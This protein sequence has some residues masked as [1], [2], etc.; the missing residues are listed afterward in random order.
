MK[1]RRSTRR[2]RGFI[3]NPYVFGAGGG[4]PTYTFSNV[5]LLLHGSARPFIDSS[6]NKRP[7]CNQIA[8]C[9]L[10]SGKIAF[11]TT[12]SGLFVRGADTD[13]QF[14]TGAFFVSARVA[15]GAYGTTARIFDTRPVS[16]SSNG[17]AV[18][19]QAVTRAPFITIE[20]TNYGVGGGGLPSSNL[21]A[22]SGAESTISFSYDGTD[23]RCF[24]DGAL[25]WTHTVS[26]NIDTGGFICVGNSVSSNVPDSAGANTSET[27]RDLIVIKG[28]AVV[29]AAFTVP[30]TWTD[31]G[32]VIE[33]YNPVTYANVKLNCHMSGANGGTTFTDTSTG[34]KTVTPNGNAQTSTA[35][36]RIGSSSGLFDGTGDYL[37]VPDSADWDYSTADFSLEVQIR[38]ANITAR[39]IIFSN[40]LNSTTGWTVQIN[41]TSNGR[42]HINLTGDGSEIDTGSVLGSAYL[43]IQATTWQHIL[44]SRVSSFLQ[45]FYEGELV[46]TVPDTSNVTGSSQSFYFGRL[47][48]V[49]TTIDYNGHAQE[50][51]VVKGEG[52]PRSFS[53]QTAAHPDS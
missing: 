33:G 5:K 36:A 44:V 53:V 10:S 12:E 45:L 35:Q 3:I 18:T 34:A 48:T 30:T 26:L 41:L 27:L 49:S 19:V 8:R 29:T 43:P 7:V 51:R 20:G 2:Q 38:P 24:V 25:S 14:G 46:M 39:Q 52:C 37:T 6:S 23:L 31:T 17:W 40:Y 4:G 47:T 28:E 11:S 22:T 21:L 15:A 9:T 13:W 42:M 16:G 32:I 50:L 1:Q